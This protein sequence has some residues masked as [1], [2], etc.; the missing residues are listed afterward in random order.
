[1]AREVSGSRLFLA[2]A[3]IYV[4][5]VTV[6]KIF[7]FITLLLVTMPAN[8]IAKGIDVIV[9]DP[10][11]GG[12]EAGII[13]GGIKE[14]DIA[15]DLARQVEDIL[16]GLRKKVYLTRKVDQYLSIGDR[17]SRANRRM[18]DMLISLHMSNSEHFAVYMIWYETKDEELTLKQYYSLLS[19]QRRYVTKSG[20]LAGIFEDVLKDGFDA[21]VY[22][23]EM[24]LPL[25]ASIGAPAVLVE[26]PSKEMDYAEQLHRIATAIVIG[27]LTYEDRG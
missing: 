2:K 19:R 15:L 5:N 20:E 10:G 7:L 14:K 17:I 21:S 16:R 13:A 23:R 6:R 8:S 25:L 11:H 1:M 26:I 24:F 22:H 3:A 12:Y 4:E 9:I 18:P 27:V